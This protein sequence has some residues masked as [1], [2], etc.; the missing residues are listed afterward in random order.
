[1]DQAIALPEVREAF[2]RQV[3]PLGSAPDVGAFESY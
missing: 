1:V 3:R 2:L